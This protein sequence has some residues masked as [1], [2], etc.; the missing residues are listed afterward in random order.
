[1][2]AQGTDPYHELSKCIFKIIDPYDGAISTGFFISENGLALTAYHVVHPKGQKQ[3]HRTMRIKYQGA[4][5]VARLIIPEN[6]DFDKLAKKDI[7][8]LKVEGSGFQ[9]ASV[10]TPDPELLKDRRVLAV[11]F[12]EQD[13]FADAVPIY[14]KVHSDFPVQRVRFDPREAQDCLIIVFENFRYLPG[15]SGSPILDVDSRHVIA[16]QTGTDPSGAAI[17]IE[18][19]D[20]L[21][22]PKQLHG[23]PSLSLSPKQK[24]YLEIGLVDLKEGRRGFGIPLQDVLESWPGFAQYC[25]P[26]EIRHFN[27]KA[28][29]FV[30]GHTVPARWV[31]RETELNDLRKLIREGQ[32]PVI[33]IVAF[34][35]TGKSTLARK[36]L[37][38][39]FDKEQGWVPKPDTLFE[40]GLW[41]SFYSKPSLDQFLE[42]A[43]RYAVN[44]AFDPFIYVTPFAKATLLKKE[45]AK[46]R[47]LIVLDG[48]EVMLKEDRQSPYFG[49]CKDRVLRDFLIDVC[50]QTRS[51]FIITSRYPLIDLADVAE[52]FQYKLGN[53]RP[54]DALALMQAL[55][56]KGEPRHIQ[57]VCERYGYHVLTL[58]ALAGLLVRY[59]GGDIQAIRHLPQILVTD[60]QSAKLKSILDGWWESLKEAEH[61]FLTRASAFHWLPITEET[62]PVLTFGDPTAPEFRQMIAR[63]VDSQLLSKEE[64]KGK[65]IYTLH[66]LIKDDFYNRMGEKEKQEVHLA[67]KRYAEGLFVPDEPQALEDIKPLLELYY[68]CLKAGFYEEAYDCLFKKADIIDKKLHYPSYFYRL[69]EERTGLFLAHSLILYKLYCWG[70]Y[71]LALSI[72]EP[73]VEAFRCKLW[74]TTPFQ[75]SNLLAW[76]GLFWKYTGSP[77]EC[78]RRYWEALKEVEVHFVDIRTR[79]WLADALIQIGH[80]RDALSALD[81]VRMVREDLKTN[82]TREYC[83]GLAGIAHA[84]L[85]EIMVAMKELAHAWGISWELSRSRCY[86]LWRRGDLHIQRGNLQDA[87]SDFKASL[88]IALKSQ[89]R[90]SEGHALRGLGDCYR[91]AG[92]FTSARQQYQQALVIAE[93][94]GY[95]YLEAEVRVGLA[96]LALA[97][98]DYKGVKIEAS[99]ALKIA[100][101]CGYKVQATEAHLLLARVARSLGEEMKAHQHLKAAHA[102][103]EQTEHYWTR[104]ELIELEQ[105]I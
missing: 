74:D 85:G 40:G 64:Q 48:L 3:P 81:D 65:T 70:Q 38:E 47:F 12:Q 13:L 55:G 69:D 53:L 98:Q 28:F 102:L 35:G 104:Q 18:F 44:E 73:L 87:M 23:K 63:L 8:V 6:S 22:K 82:F 16:M 71:N 60:P 36:L 105:R 92:D 52:H 95:R 80:F 77:Q 83:F 93:E 39:F 103:V 31:G 56:V 72:L 19:P 5:L 66:P 15:M 25:S 27:P 88:D 43:C 26:L 61:R 17:T 84:N 45:L 68:H 62:L 1:M 99:K 42:E 2:K 10:A 11:G 75:K 57:E 29:E 7:A 79:L 51:Q 9:A 33:S 24:R 41:F 30:R 100:E 76:T 32:Y 50:T 20:S 14:G 58:Q 34:G 97:E 67:L 54:E 101:E 21:F 4:D 94:T 46:H 89:F 37:E 86:W 90:D 96:R 49:T 91:V 59:Y 78:I